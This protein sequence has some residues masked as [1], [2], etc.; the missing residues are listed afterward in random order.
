M[1]AARRIF[2]TLAVLL[3]ATLPA[4]FQVRAQGMLA[5]LIADQIQVIGNTRLQA[6]G[7]VIVVY[8]DIRLSAQSVI[9]DRAT[10]QLQ[11]VGPIVIDDGGSTLILADAAELSAD[12]RN[13]ILESARI[14]LDQQLQIAA[15]EIARVD[16]RYTQMT[17]A[18]ASS[19]QVCAE[20]PVPLWSIRASRVI[21]D[22]EEHQLYFHDAQFRVFDVPI[23]YLPR[24]RLPDPTVERATGFL[25]PEI[26]SNS[27]VGVGIVVPYFIAIGDHADVTIAPYWATRSRTVELRY[28]QAFRS[29]EIE[30]NAAYS[31]DEI[32]P[33]QPRYYVFGEGHF[34]L[35]RDFDLDLRLELVSD[36]AYLLDYG[37]SLTD[38]L[39]NSVT[40]ERARRDQYVFAEIGKW[41]TLRE[42]E[43]PISDQLPFAQTDVIYEQRMFP[44]AIGGELTFTF[45]AHGHFREETP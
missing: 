45:D 16:G 7:D 44:A 23:A 41:E 33:G 5:T 20:N 37:T 30:F 19:C 24:L 27:Q 9:F 10:G 39:R 31:E 12:L 8:E 14:V 22:Q 34:D 3:A 35:P 17:K 42:D 4:P 11:I 2:L 43:I 40:V 28:R 29:G 13:G 36:A 25:A 15:A 6:T 1:T 38:R 18:V 26:R 32:L 21:H